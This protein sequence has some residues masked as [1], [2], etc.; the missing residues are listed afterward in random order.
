VHPLYDDLVCY[1][2][3]PNDKPTR[4]QTQWRY[5]LRLQNPEMWETPTVIDYPAVWGRRYSAAH[6]NAAIE[7]FKRSPWGPGPHYPKDAV[8]AADGNRYWVQE[9]PG[10][11]IMCENAKTPGFAHGMTANDVSTWDTVEEARAMLVALLEHLGEEGQA[12]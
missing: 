7:A 5:Q 10:Y 6:L 11:K 8:V 9:W 3:N 4:V 12:E 1:V 2:A